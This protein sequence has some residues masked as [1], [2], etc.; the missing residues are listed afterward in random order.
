M[1]KQ[2]IPKPKND[3][4]FLSDIAFIIFASGF[5]FSIVKERF[6]LIKKAFYNFNIEK[7][8]KEKNIEKIMKADGM[9]KNKGKIEAIIENAKMCS[10]LKKDYCSVLKWI[11]AL[12]KQHK[13]DPLLNP[14]LN[15]AFQRFKR[16]GKTTSGWLAGLHNAKGSYMVVDVPR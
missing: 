7:L 10:Q 15:E 6:P 1:P 3:D 12:K 16:I 11:G 2:R 8:S 4:E 9:I 5:R 14:S 13:K